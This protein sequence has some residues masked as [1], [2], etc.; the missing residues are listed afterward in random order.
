MKPA[1]NLR[2]YIRQCISCYSV[3]FEFALKNLLTLLS[4]AI[5]AVIPKFKCQDPAVEFA[6]KG[7]HINGLEMSL[8][9]LAYSFIFV[10]MYSFNY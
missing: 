9:L 8:I 3:Y 6:N 2:Q 10:T 5:F 7:V 1:E 4:F